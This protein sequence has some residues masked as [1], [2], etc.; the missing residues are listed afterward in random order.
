VSRSTRYTEAVRAFEDWRYEQKAKPADLFSTAVENP[1]ESRDFW[2]A[3]ALAAIERAARTRSEFTV[4]DVVWS[5]MI[6]N[7]GWGAAMQDA[8]RKGWIKALG[9]VSGN[10]G[11]HGRPVRLWASQVYD[12]R[13]V[14]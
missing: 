6:D 9:W 12:A 5:P 2:R 10:A 1:V 13:A 4:E 11:R 7:R 3:E 14:R 8:A